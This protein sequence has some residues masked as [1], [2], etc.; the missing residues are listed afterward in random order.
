[1][2]LALLCTVVAGAIG[3]FV[4]KADPKVIA[5][6]AVF[7]PLIAY[8][9]TKLKFEGKNSWHAR[10]YDGLNTLRSQLLY[11]L[12][13]LPTLDQVARIAAERDALEIEMQAEWDRWLLLDWTGMLNHSTTHRANGSLGD[14]SEQ[15]SQ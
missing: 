2:L 4:P 1:M 6:F 9:A 14:N 8:V 11:Q 13:E 5:G 10:L 3:F 7:P 12:P 15:L